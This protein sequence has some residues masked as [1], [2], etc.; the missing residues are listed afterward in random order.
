MLTLLKTLALLLSKNKAL[1]T[2]FLFCAVKLDER[3][4]GF[5]K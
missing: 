5:H 4:D 3:P 1:M 2:V